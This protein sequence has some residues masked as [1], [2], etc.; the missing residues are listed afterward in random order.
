MR[1][2]TYHKFSPNRAMATSPIPRKNIRGP[3]RVGLV[4]RRSGFVVVVRGV[5]LVARSV[6]GPCGGRP[7][8]R[9]GWWQG[10]AEWERKGKDCL[11][12]FM[13]VSCHRNKLL[14][15]VVGDE[16]ALTIVPDL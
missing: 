10:G 16:L 1:T 8:C 3:D 5:G 14:Y 7:R 13:N 2:T 15:D 9:P 4:T 6:G 11:S 12:W